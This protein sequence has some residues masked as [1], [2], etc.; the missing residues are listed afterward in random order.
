YAVWN[1][2]SYE[3]SRWHPI[4]LFILM[5]ASIVLAILKACS[6]HFEIYG[7]VTIH[8]LLGVEGITLLV[9]YLS[10]IIIVYARY[11]SRSLPYDMDRLKAKY[12]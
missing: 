6:I 10:I 9:N 4:P 12:Q 3:E 11:K 8:A 2:A 7:F 1:A 5:F